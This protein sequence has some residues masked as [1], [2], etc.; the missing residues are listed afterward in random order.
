ML[1][2]R[3]DITGASLLMYLL[4]LLLLLFYFSYE[5]FVSSTK[6]LS[7]VESYPQLKQRT[8]RIG[9]TIN[10]VV[11]RGYHASSQL[12]V[13]LLSCPGNEARLLKEPNNLPVPTFYNQ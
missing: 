3:Y 4:F 5:T 6:V 1:K 7:D 10:R 13:S 8:E 11:F 9:Y 12:Q 2:M